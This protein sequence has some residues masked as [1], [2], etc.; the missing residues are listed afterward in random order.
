MSN[1]VPDGSLIP[2]VSLE[3]TGERLLSS[4]ITRE[5][6]LS[7]WLALNRLEKATVGYVWYCNRNSRNL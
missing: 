1:T 4:C 2:S 7:R 6:D 5:T 3:D